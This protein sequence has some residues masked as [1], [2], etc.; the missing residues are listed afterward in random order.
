MLTQSP[1]DTYS[2][3]AQQ[4]MMDIILNVEDGETLDIGSLKLKVGEFAAK[5]EKDEQFDKIRDELKKATKVELK[6]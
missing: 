4:L 6:K 3:T 2:L 5:I 1:S